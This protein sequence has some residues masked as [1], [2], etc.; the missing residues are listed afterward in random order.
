MSGKKMRHSLNMLFLLDMIR[1]YH[2]LFCR[3][4]ADPDPTDLVSTLLCEQL[5]RRKI[6]TANGLEA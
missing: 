4:I 6:D 2:E 5:R 3:T 1:I